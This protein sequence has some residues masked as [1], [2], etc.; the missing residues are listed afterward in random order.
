V[1]VVEA[2]AAVGVEFETQAVPMAH[3]FDPEALDRLFDDAG[4]TPGGSVAD[5]RVRLWGRTVRVTPDA[6]I[7][8]D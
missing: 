6:V 1:A 5:V 3:H 2:L 7:V 8:E 4:G